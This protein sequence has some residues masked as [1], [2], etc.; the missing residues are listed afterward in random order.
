MRTKT[1]E[2]AEEAP[3]VPEKSTHAR[4]VVGRATYGMGLERA[5]LQS[6]ALDSNSQDEAKNWLLNNARLVVLPDLV[7]GTLDAEIVL[8]GKP[9]PW[10]MDM[11]DLVQMPDELVNQWLGGIYEL[12]AT[13]SPFF[14]LSE[15][16]L[17]K[18][19]SPS[20]SDSG[21]GTR[22]PVRSRASHTTRRRKSLNSQTSPS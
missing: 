1:I 17:K 4:I 6:E 7:A 8:N 22:T 10:P 16:D 18:V 14:N 11:V 3:D 19:V 5:R 13:W 9:I 12:N 15:D 21:N 2:Y 20:T